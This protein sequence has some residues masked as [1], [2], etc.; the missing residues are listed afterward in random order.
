MLIL[1]STT[2]NTQTLLAVWVGLMQDGADANI[3]CLLK[4]SWKIVSRVHSAIP[5]E[6]HI[7]MHSEVDVISVRQEHKL[8][9]RFHKDRMER[10]LVK[11][12]N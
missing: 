4:V 10:T 8:E 5:R 7:K 1:C 12:N 3:A 6:A 11:T 2:D 9:S